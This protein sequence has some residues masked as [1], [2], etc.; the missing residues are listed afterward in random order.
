MSLT[1]FLSCEGTVFECKQIGYCHAELP[2]TI[3]LLETVWCR[4]T[5]SQFQFNVVYENES[6]P[7]GSANEYI[8][9]A[10]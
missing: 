10:S 3:F 5:E 2:S 6:I 8:P 1:Y 4:R 7:I 9:V